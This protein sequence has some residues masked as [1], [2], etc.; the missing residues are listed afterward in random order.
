MKLLSTDIDETTVEMTFA[1]NVQLDD[2]AKLLIVRM[3]FEENEM[4]SVAW[5]RLRTLSQARDFIGAE[6]QRLKTAIDAVS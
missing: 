4:K 3:P 6:M 5:H 1:D 2:A